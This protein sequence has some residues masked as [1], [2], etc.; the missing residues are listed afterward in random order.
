M[1]A[2]R[3]GFPFSRRQQLTT[4]NN[5]RLELGVSFSSGL[6][7]WFRSCFFVGFI[8][9]EDFTLISVAQHKFHQDFRPGGRGSGCHF[10]P[11]AGTRRGVVQ[12]CGFIKDFSCTAQIS[13]GFQWYRTNLSRIFARRSGLGMS[14]SAGRGDPAGR[15]PGMRFY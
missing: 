12:E 8:I 4:N 5:N 15:R 11:A 13:L 14:F 7:G 1:F 9:I 3:A 2:G 10:R 6:P